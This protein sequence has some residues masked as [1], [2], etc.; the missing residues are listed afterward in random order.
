MSIYKS[1]QKASNVIGLAKTPT[2]AELAIYRYANLILLCSPDHQQLS[3]LCQ[4]FFE[5]YLARVTLTADETRFAATN[6]V[7]DKFYEHNVSLMKRLKKCFSTAEAHYKAESLRTDDDA[8]SSFYSGCSRLFVSYGLWLEETKLNES[9]SM[10][11][12]E[13][14]P[15]YDANRLMTIFAGNYV[16]Y[17]F[18]EICGL[19]NL[20]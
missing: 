7:A 11:F 14:P 13:F 2:S 19:I 12:A 20:V 16:I 4:R 5:L 1:S 3:L 17:G 6:G 8:M 10:R 18:S 9:S 15:Q